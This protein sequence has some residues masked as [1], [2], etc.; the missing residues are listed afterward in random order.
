MNKAERSSAIVSSLFPSAV[1]DQLYVPKEEAPKK[2]DRKSRLSAFQSDEMR[3]G[4]SDDDQEKTP[5]T[6]SPI[7]TLYENTTIMCELVPC[8]VLVSRKIESSV[9]SLL[10]VCCSSF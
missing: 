10:L 8:C 4:D 9:F 2:S 7:A 5:L 6:G 3:F 1:R